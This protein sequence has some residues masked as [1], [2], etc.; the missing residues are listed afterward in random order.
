MEKIRNGFMASLAI[1][2]ASAYVSCSNGYSDENESKK[3][4]NTS[5]SSVETLSHNSL[6]VAT[7][8]K[9]S[10]T[11]IISKMESMSGLKY[12]E[13]T[14]TETTDASWNLCKRADHECDSTMSLTFTPSKCNI[15]ISVTKTHIKAKLTKTSK[16]YKFEEGSYIVKVG[17]SN[18]EGIN[19]YSYGVYRADGTLYI[20]LDGNG[21]IAIETEYK[22]S[23]KKTDTEN[24]D[25]FTI[26][27]DY[28]IAN[29]QVTLTYTS[30]GQYKSCLG[31]L[32]NDGQ[33]ILFASNPIV[34]TIKTFKK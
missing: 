9:E 30:N 16:L 10:N 23:D 33:N 2:I 22:Y 29:N 5:W 3:L 4:E 24:I 25:E 31:T 12:T 34:S 20:P 28:K 17:P 15:K 7:D 21:C 26:S 27:A 19:V 1:A 8:K 18:Y 14:S 6:S 32:T 11:V 13:E